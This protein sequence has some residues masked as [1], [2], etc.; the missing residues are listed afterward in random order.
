MASG[1]QLSFQ[2]GEVSPSLRFRSDAVSYASGLSK[3]TNMYVRRA[4][5][6][7][8]RAGFKFLELASSQLDIP[9]KGAKMGIIGF[10]YWASETA[11]WQDV[12]YG[13]YL[14]GL[15]PATTKAFNF[16]KSGFFG[17]YIPNTGGPFPF[18]SSVRFTPVPDS[19]FVTPGIA[20]L[21][22]ES[23]SSG[24]GNV[25]IS[26]G[27]RDPEAALILPTGKLLVGSTSF[28]STMP[29]AQAPFFPV[30]YL[31]TATFRNGEEVPIGE[32]VSVD[33][34][35]V[36]GT[37]Q[38]CYPH[39]GLYVK[40]VLTF[41][42]ANLADVVSFTL[43]RASGR[44]GMA[45]SYYRQVAKQVYQ[46]TPSTS[47]TIVG[48]N[49]GYGSATI[50]GIASTAA[51]PIGAALT[52]PG[53]GFPIGTVVQSK[54]ATTLVLSLGSSLPDKLANPQS[55]TFTTNSTVTFTDYGA[56]TPAITPPIDYHLMAD[57][58]SLGGSF[59]RP[60]LGGVQASAYY[61]QR[62]IMAMKPGTTSATKPG[63]ILA[64]KLGA[65]RQVVGPLI[66][67]DTEAFSFNVPITDGTPVVALLGMERLIAFTE[68]GVYVIRGGEQ[69]ILTPT[70]VNPLLI[71]GEGCSSTIEPKMVGR[72]GYFVN[73]NHT[74]LMAIEFGLDA[75]LSLFDA[76]VFSEH[77]MEEDIVQIEALEGNENTVYMLRRDGK[78]AQV[79]VSETES[80]GFSLLETD[81]YIESI[82]R[83]KAKR[84]YS[85]NAV[86]LTNSEKYQDVL[87]AYVIRNGKRTLEQIE[88]RDD[89]HLE[90]EHFA[91]CYGS[92]GMRLAEFGVEGYYKLD[93]FPG[94]NPRINIEMITDWEAGSVVSIKT[95]MLLY[96]GMSQ[97]DPFTVIHFYYEDE[98]GNTQYARL[99]LDGTAPLPLGG[100]EFFNEYKGYF[101]AEVP[102]TLRN[103]SGQGLS[104]TEK[105]KKYTRWLPAFNT[106]SH[107]ASTSGTPLYG[108]AI[109]SFSDHLANTTE[110]APVS[111]M[112]DGEVLSSPLNP[113]KPTINLVKTLGMTEPTLSI[114]LGDYYSWG[115][116]GVPYT[117]EFETLDLE[118][119]GEKTL[120]DSK[121]LLNAVGVGFN[122]S[123]G[124]FFGM[125]G[126]DL[127]NM[128]EIQPREDEDMSNQ[129]KNTSG[130][131]VVNVPAGWNEA[132]RVNIKQVD[133]A[134]ITILSV[135]PKGISGD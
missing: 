2:Y 69:G 10:T 98:E 116:V 29:G 40:M 107:L 32:K 109:A 88:V 110:Q 124:G 135:Y 68:R 9:S 95:N 5:G 85:P 53:R 16:P 4:G 38:V 54:T 27:F 108:P 106:I 80:V 7:S 115:Y 79:T 122:E 117:S 104:T 22:S 102:V 131:L 93:T 120:T 62:L 130:H 50:S 23:G 121:K 12:E 70:T 94:Y 126:Q 58:L 105:N 90:G 6:V 63:T 18:P 101:T 133:P 83:S 76:S 119:G 14:D 49:I 92:F 81:G 125:P 56:D 78:L 111:I 123:R 26:V 1:K 59:F 64:S 127:T 99:I 72:R 39:A 45:T 47:V 77:F 51:V 48:G 96:G 65:T 36:P 35:G 57:K 71:S 91:D 74:K 103:A 129:S 84:P 113:Y 11:S 8:N 89:K 82:Y 134:P 33:E 24:R 15:G 31:F 13:E 114:D 52:T 30:S 73:N 55:W 132:G 20:A 28:V 41:L 67:S 46:N 87:K 112:A 100:P 17:T 42:P 128:E 19:V 61:Q 3:L 97:P 37:M 118:S 25:A 86:D 44:G 21:S 34:S 43:Y 66:Y 75:N 60:I